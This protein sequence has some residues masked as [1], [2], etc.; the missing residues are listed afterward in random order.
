MD[1]S[2]TEIRDAIVHRRPNAVTYGDKLYATLIAPLNL[3][4]NERLI[5]V[6]HGALHYL[7][8]Q[9][10]HAPDGFLIQHHAIALEP[11]ASIAVQLEQ[12]SVRWR[13][14][15]WRS[16]IRRFRRRTTCRVPEAEV[17]GI[18]PLFAR[19]E[20]FLQGN[21]TRVSFRENAA[22]GRVLHVATHAQADTIDPLHSRILLAPATQPA[23][24]PDSLLAKDIYNLKL[25]NVALV[26]L[27]ACETGLG[28]IAARRRDP[29]LH[30]RVF[31]CGRD[32]PDRLDV[33][34][35]RRVERADHANLLRAT[36]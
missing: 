16:A 10:L 36:G 22:A 2:V 11:S 8:F 3:R 7:P 12:R 30:A 26:T 25:N 18:A 29:R 13:A 6:P 33:A 20:V 31:L 15:S 35:R 17:R 34:G 5:I 32:E 23:D 9:A 14:R 28:R 1:T 19:N 24:G 21:A 4:D 27:S